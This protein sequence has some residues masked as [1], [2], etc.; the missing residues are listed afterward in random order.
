MIHG[1]KLRFSRLMYASCPT[2]PE[3]M[4]NGNMVNGK[5]AEVEMCLFCFEQVS[6]YLIGVPFLN[7]AVLDLHLKFGH[8]IICY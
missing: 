5:Y 4:K 3:G 2:S 8:F 6:I 7:N 1:G